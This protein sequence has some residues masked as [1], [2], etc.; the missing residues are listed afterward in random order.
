M[1]R[2][3]PGTMPRAT[4]RGTA[5]EPSADPGD[6]RLDPESSTVAV[7]LRN[8]D[9]WQ[10]HSLRVAVAPVGG[11]VALTERHYLAPGQSTQLAGPLASG[12]YEVRVWVDG[13]ERTRAT[14]R[15]DDS[16]AGTAVVELGNGVVSLTR[17]ASGA[18]S[19][20]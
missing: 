6:R 4:T 13:V 20:G 12:E 16:A 19:T 7:R 14:C 2:F 11:D 5:D 8:Y 9:H 3:D 15:L 1:R 17:P 10:G 18:P